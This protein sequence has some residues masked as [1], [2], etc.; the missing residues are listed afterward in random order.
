MDSKDRLLSDVTLYASY[1]RQS[2]DGKVSM[3]AYARANDVATD[4]F[5]DSDGGY[6]CC[7]DA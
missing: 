5:Y 2:A 1:C 3:A 7:H 6:K 4:F